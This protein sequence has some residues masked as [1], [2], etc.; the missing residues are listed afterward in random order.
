MLKNYILIAFRQF[1][2]HKM[3]SALNV[4]CLAIGI[5][6]CLLIVEYVLHENSV[7]ASL[8]N[9]R[10]Q[11]FLTSHWK[12]KDTGPEITTVG[13]LAKALRQRY[14]GLVS[15][16]YRFNPVTT[17][18]SAGDKHFKENVSI[19]DT[20]MVTIYGLSLLYGDPTHAFINNRSAI[21]T[22]ELAMK[23]FGEKNVINKTVTLN[24]LTATTQDYKVSAVLK[25]IPY[26][27]VINLLDKKGYGMFIPFEGNNYYPGG[28]GEENWTGFNT[29]GFVELQ[30]GISPGQLTAPV[31]NLL[32][33]N[34]PD[35]INKNLDVQFRPLSTYYLD[36]NNAAVSKTLSILSLVALGIL[37]LAI[38]NFVNITIGTSSYRIKEIG[39][40]KVFGSRRRQL[41]YQYLV[42]SVILTIFAGLLS[43]IFYGIFR[44]AFNEIL[45][46]SLKSINGFQVRE[47]ATLAVIILISGLLAGIYPA[48]ILSGSEMVNSVKGKLGSV[49]KGVWLKKSL[50][51]LQFT[52]AI[53]VFIFSM[54]ISKQVKY[55]FNKDLGYDKEQLMVVT[56]FPKQWDSAGVE[57]I[58]SIRKSMSG[59]SAVKDAA[60]SFDIP[61]RGTVNQF[62]VN[63]EGPKN[64]QT[65]TVQSIGVD[66]EY[67]STFGLSLVE[68]RFFNQGGVFVPGEV[69]INQSAEKSFGWSSATGR[70]F[71][72]PSIGVDMKVVGVV[73]DFHLGSLHES[74]A[75]L[76]LFH[77]KT[78]LAYRYLTIKLRAG[79]LADAIA[80]VR[81]KW[82]DVSPN[83]PFEYF[84]MDEKLQSMYQAE[85]QLKKAASIAT[86][87]MLL[88]VMLGIFGVLS[89]ALTKR[90]KEI[91]V[92]KVLGA[93]VHHILGLFVR[94]YAG[95]MLI[96][97][98]IAWPLSYYFSNQWLQQYVYRIPQAAG[99][100]FTA[101][102][103]VAVIA[104]VL[105]SLQCLKVAL[106]NPVHSLRSE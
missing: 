101:A 22:E 49:E 9:D 60:V 63:P 61:E 88:I 65:V 67:A 53:V 33:L 64:N 41:V 43:V 23:L 56:A 42:E 91:A 48:I 19:G 90:M 6:F 72:M 75:P 105:I 98:L 30:P 26:N 16:Y 36:A 51:V 2:R 21:I 100:Y 81:A 8:K 104:L 69:V 3:F 15:N 14:P 73:R 70:V 24:N 13:P 38:I 94:Q 78:T 1:S 62:V 29:V 7:N 44:P 27:T 82:K 97:T 54:T 46:T 47:L 45:N 71:R 68:G 84:F 25:T 57:K 5:S 18:V 11:Y 99:V 76:V 32:K 31:R 37:L 58:E 17:S 77:V 93:E 79:N 102:L 95:L 86:G 106:A 74:I 89:L 39:L 4:F 59:I 10:Q 80:L 87:L 12:V 20:S 85:L 83:S 66:E 34:S 50:L 52:I 96:A 55:F 103:F 92:R 40:R 28:S 35:N